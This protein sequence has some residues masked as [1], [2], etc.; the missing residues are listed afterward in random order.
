MHPE[1]LEG[2]EADKEALQKLFNTV[3]S[4]GI[5]GKI[6]TIHAGTVK[7]ATAIQ[8]GILNITTN[9]QTANLRTQNTWAKYEGIGLYPTM[10]KNGDLTATI[11]F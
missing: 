9:S 2:I 7:H 5:N 4:L 8:N 1:L 11:L 6:S 10:L 3:K